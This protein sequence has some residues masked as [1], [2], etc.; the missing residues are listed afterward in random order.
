MTR[1]S[2]GS[3]F[4]RQ[5]PKLAEALESYGVEAKAMMNSFPR[6]LKTIDA[7]WGAR[8]C[9][10]YLDNLLF[11]DRPN[12][13]GFP[14]E[15][16]DE[17]LLI[18][19][20]HESTFPTV[21]THRS[22]PVSKLRVAE[23]MDRIKALAAVV[24]QRADKA[25]SAS[26]QEAVVGKTVQADKEEPRL[27]ELTTL[28][29]VVEAL[30]QLEKGPLLGRREHRLIGEY[31][32]EAGLVSREI[33]DRA[34]AYQAK[35]PVRH[36]IGELLV[37]EHSL[38]PHQLNHA[39]C[40]QRDV[41]V[42]DVAN[43]EASPEAIRLVPLRIARLKNAM[44][45]TLYGNH[46]VVAVANPFDQE[47]QEYFSFLSG[48]RALLVFARPERIALALGNYGQNAG[49]GAEGHGNGLIKLRGEPAGTEESA[50]PPAGSLRV[51]LADESGD[52]AVEEGG[53]GAEEE[54]VVDFSEQAAG[55][56]ENDETV[57]GLV[58]KTINDAVRVGASDIHF[59]AFPSVRSAQ[60]RYRKDGV[61]EA[62]SEYPI[63]YHAAVVSRLKIMAD[64]DIA[65]KRKA[66]DGRI[67]FGQG[68][69]KLDLRVSTIPTAKGLEVVTVRLLNSGKPLP[70]AKIG[71]HP[72][73]LAAFR[74]QVMKPYGLILVCGPTG[75]GKTTTLH[76]VLRELNTPERKIWTAEDPVEVVQKNISQVQVLPKIGWTFANALRSFLRADPD[77]IMVGEIRDAETAKVAVEASMTGH[78][79]LSTVHTNSAAETLAR[80]F[81]LEIQPFNLADALQAVLAQRLARRICPAC[82]EKFTF[83]EEELE[84]LAS[85][86]SL[87]GGGKVPA[88]AERD[89]LLARWR[90]QF[91]AEGES[92]SGMRAMGC[93]AC[94]GTGYRGRLG[95]HELL[96]VTPEIRRLIRSGATT[97]DI[98]RQAVKEGMKTLRQ[99]GIE[100]VAQALT[101]LK[102][103]RTTCL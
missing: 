100:K 17:L 18:K 99:D 80:M 23:T 73:T 33:L 22:D 72:V 79:V 58:N 41:P 9:M 36:L 71:M 13:Q 5:Y 3:E 70:L 11:S 82:G 61:M 21:S 47:L 66:Q 39:L 43:V 20:I 8:E 6:L 51:V 103:V 68:A 93:A 91:V 57:I 84:L 28:A 52:E 42:V 76:S 97:G 83:G 67:A 88:K 69:R 15:V 37:S 46:L 81:D 94:N 96:V 27:A 14:N 35:A 40:L 34:L 31:L 98:F 49:E 92:L 12:R 89:K 74:E 38:K 30:N 64:L 45:I 62:H 60:I 63:S 44:P 10:F 102:E 16:I 78:L 2:E 55:I 75:S 87:A 77:V 90:S 4:S 25:E 48:T 85:E 86:Y 29:A 50:V 24:K 65:E 56:D 59:E 95:I 19:N 1:K 26:G 54:G 7:G 53:D 101:D 32:I